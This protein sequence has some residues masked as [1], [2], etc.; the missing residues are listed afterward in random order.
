M[1]PVGN[2][3]RLLVWVLTQRRR[4]AETYGKIRE[5]IDIDERSWLVV[6]GPWRV[7]RQMQ[8]ACIL[9]RPSLAYIGLFLLLSG[10]LSGAQ[11]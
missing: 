10:K 2:G 1:L 6:R 11:V 9:A 4:V 3:L 8:S 5:L 7:V